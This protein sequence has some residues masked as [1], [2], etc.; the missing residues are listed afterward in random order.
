ML[1][2]NKI[3]KDKEMTNT[4]IVH[5]A[6]G[7]G[8]NV[9]DDVFTK[10]EQLGEGFANIE[11]HYLDTSRAN[12]D[13]IEPQGEFWLIKTKANSKSEIMGSGGERRTHA[14]DIQANVNEY[15]DTNGFLKWNPSQFHI[16]TFSASG[17]Y[18]NSPLI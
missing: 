8:I 18:T 11:Y 1:K 7:C 12:I 9:S 16:V 10:I 6:G 14:A 15:L 2:K 13:K 3:K 5:A 17:G 4:M